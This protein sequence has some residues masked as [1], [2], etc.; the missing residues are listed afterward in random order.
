MKYFFFGFLFF[1]SC[2]TTQQINYTSSYNDRNE[3][4]LQGIINKS[5]I[6]NDTTFTWFGNNYKYAQPAKSA[7]KIFSENKN[8]FKL[9]VFG[10]TWCEDTHNLLP[11]FYKLIA[12]S[13]Y[14]EKRIT[15]VGVDRNKQSGNELS[16]KY[17]IKNV[18][19]FIVLRNDGTEVGRVVE[20]GKGNGIDVELAEIVSSFIK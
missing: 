14:P 13:N 4:V 19:C 18:P 15:L 9:V 8:K 7:V 20:Y 2:K 5:L 6:E 17:N 16:T 12:V 3:K 11:T 10:G 1:M